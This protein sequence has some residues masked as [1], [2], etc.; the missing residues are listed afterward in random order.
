MVTFTTSHA[1]LTDGNV[2]TQTDI[3]WKNK[4]ENATI[5]CNQTMGAQ[6]FRMYWYRQLPGKTMELIVFTSTARKNHDFGNFSEEKFSATKPDYSTGTFT[7]KN[8][9]LADKGLYFCAATGHSDADVLS[10]C[11]KTAL[12]SHT[13]GYTLIHHVGF[14]TAVCGGIIYRSNFT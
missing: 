6:L 12:I 8:L 13:P 5:Y 4:G 1:G 9:E 14:H 2:V 3:L 7:V 10:S 11:T